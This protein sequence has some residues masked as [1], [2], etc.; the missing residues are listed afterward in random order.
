[1]GG[2]KSR[3]KVEKASK[4]IGDELETN[5]VEHVVQQLSLF[6]VR[7]EGE[8]FIEQANQ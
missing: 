4:A 3:E 8:K 2:I 7:E 5:K 6:K 1:M